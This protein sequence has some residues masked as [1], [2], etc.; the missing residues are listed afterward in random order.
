MVVGAFE[1]SSELSG[2]DI[3]LKIST[4]THQLRQSQFNGICPA[5]Q[6]CGVCRRSTRRIVNRPDIDTIYEQIIVIILD[7]IDIDN[8][9]LDIPR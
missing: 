6:S 7:S 5:I 1:L 4:L 2:V 9:D 3:D 8:T